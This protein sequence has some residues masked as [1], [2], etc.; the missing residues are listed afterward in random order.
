[1]AQ[2]NAS[3]RPDKATTITLNFMA[4][5]CR[6]TTALKMQLSVILDDRF[7]IKAD[8]KD[9]LLSAIDSWQGS[10][11]CESIYPGSIKL[12]RAWACLKKLMPY[13]FRCTGELSSGQIR[14]ISLERVYY[15]E[16]FF[17]VSVK[18]L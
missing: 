1:M 11:T 4:R 2:V 17:L 6:S 18:I 12:K 16:N 7:C 13:N 10:E 9:Y 3:T 8:F 5:P 15:L 14:T